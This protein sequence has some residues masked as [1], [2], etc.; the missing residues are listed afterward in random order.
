MRR[1]GVGQ[2]ID[3]SVRMSS[4]SGLSGIFDLAL[5][6]KVEAKECR[7]DLENL[8]KNSSLT[9]TE[10]FPFPLS[11]VESMVPGIECQ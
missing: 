11:C 1:L 9:K 10:L 3:F 6:I 7:C 8:P 2:G 5:G 4:H